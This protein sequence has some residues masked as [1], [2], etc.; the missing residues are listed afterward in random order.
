[1][2]S[3][4]FV[5]PVFFGT[6]GSMGGYLGLCTRTLGLEAA[7]SSSVDLQPNTVQAMG[8]AKLLWALALLSLAAPAI[9][10]PHYMVIVPAI[11]SHPTMENICVLLRFLPETVNL[12]VTLTIRTQNYTLVDKDVEKPGTFE[13]ISFRVPD[14]LSG[15]TSSDIED[16]VASVHVLI[17]KDGI[18]S[19][20]GRKKVLVRNA[21]IRHIIEPDKPFYKPGETVSF[22]IVRLDEE[23]KAINRTIP[24]IQLEDP[25]GNRIGQ[26]V[27]VEPRH[28]IVDLSFPLA[29]E[30]ALGTYVI[31]V[32]NANPE[33]GKRRFTVQEYELHK[34][35]VWFEP[36]PLIRTSDE[37]FE[38]TVCGKYTYGKTVRGII[39]LSLERRISFFFASDTEETLFHIRKEYT[40]QTDKTGCATFTING[41]DVNLSQKGYDRSIQASAEME[42]EGTGVKSTGEDT[43]IISAKEVELHFVLLN[44]FYKQGF[45]Y[46]GLMYVSVE[47]SPI[48]NRTVYLT[49]DVD[50]VQTHTTYVTNEN[51]VVNFSLDTTTWNNTMVSLRGRYSMENATQSETSHMSIFEA[52]TWLKPFYSESSS[53][54]EIQQ[55]E[56]EVP[57]GKDQEVRVEYILDRKELGPDADHVDFYYLVLSKG[58]IVYSGQKQVTVGHEET[59]KGSFSLILST[60]SDVAPIARILVYAVF[61][62]GEVAAD[63]DVFL[64]E[65]CFKQKVSL[66]FS[67]EEQLPGSEV[68][69]QIEAAPGALCSLHAVDKSV[70]LKENATLTP[71]KV[72]AAPM[73]YGSDTITG[74]GFPYRLEDFEPY[75]CLRPLGPSQRQKRSL[76]VAPW[77]QSEADVYSLLKQ[78]RLKIFTNL[79]VKKPVSCELPHPERIAFRRNEIGLPGVSGPAGSAKDTEVPL[80]LNAIEN[81]MD[82][83]AKPRTYFPETWIWDLTPVD[84]EGKA[85]HSVTVPDTITDWN[86]NAFCVADIG[87]GLSQPATL[88]VFKPF[89]VELVLPYSVVR[90]E[91]LQLK[92]TV[93][94]YLKDCIQVRVHLLESQDVEVKPCPECHFTTCLC[95]DE[96]KTFSWNVTATQLGQV[97]LS[98]TTEAEE[99][100]E[101]CGNQISV[102]P[103]R[104]RSDTV[105]KALLVKPEGVLEEE[106]HNV[107]LCSSG[108]PVLDEVSLELPGDVVSGS[109]RATVSTIGDI[110]GAALQNVDQLLQM[111][112][113]CGEQNMAKF[114]PNIFILQYL[115][116]TNQVTAENKEKG[117]EYMKSGYQRQLL[118]KRDDGSYSAFGKRDSEGNTW[119]TAFVAKAF[120]QAKPYVYIDEKHVQDALQ[121]LSQHQRPSGCFESVG[122]LFNN[123]L[124]GGVEDD[125][126]LTAYVTASLLE[127]HVEKNHSMVQD[128]LL[129]LKKNL[130]SV[131]DAYP[132][133]ILAYVFTLAGETEARQQLLK[134]LDELAIKTEGAITFSETETSAYVLLAYLSTSEVSADDITYASQIVRALTRAQNSYGGFSSTQ[135]TVVS[136]QALAKY[137]GLTYR[138][139]DDLKVLVK[140]SGGFQH[141]FHV[142]KKNRLLLQQASLPEVPGQYKVE[143]L[144]SGCVYVQTNLQYN[145]V[146]PKPE[147][148]LLHVETSPK[149]CNQTTKKHFDV[150]LQV[151]YAG[152]RET[153]NMVLLEVNMLSGYIPVKKSVKKLLINP[154]IK[155]VEPEHDKISIYLDQLDH[156]V[157]NYGFSV[158]QETEVMDLKAATVNIY[159]YY[160][161]EDKAVAEYNA[162][163][164]AE[165]MKEDQ[166]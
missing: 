121:W 58:K 73:F 30:A 27:D 6:E 68:N 98:V 43:I 26:W 10:D 151:S 40:G 94:N 32:G 149:E 108:D 162:P 106:T 78:L 140:S 64:I 138:E 57:C 9:S 132:K 128:A 93:F 116:K 34:I 123:A 101:L 54:L 8:A 158:K 161:P 66:S 124:K 31:T 142:G 82:E 80:V 44:S 105:V 46:T 117:T 95:A 19:F 65:K 24:L 41:T 85:T 75:P 50:D 20:E 35:E 163:C 12:Q 118:Y 59:L 79:E 33:L 37:E 111:P 92:A 131:S 114:V 134:D 63:V 148:F 156:S 91:T 61:D 130:T 36:T 42:E 136:L 7:E 1:M 159:D 96:A 97:N 56:E 104:G 102:A 127:A 2:R 125:L 137:A 115:E 45:P 5:V 126:S 141:E 25:N 67:E 38:V 155:K 4:H 145:K 51:G 135:D 86:A 139:I 14:F 74:R 77:Y 70:V 112:F 152:Q 48:Q 15:A 52:F 110:M 47:G 103:A 72:Y 60:S 143:L 147:G 84:E 89:F 120:G 129:C 29:S 18:V 160:H 122:R 87:F 154:L 133:A 113:G 107:F 99:T 100:Q 69:L 150:N 119:L 13:C 55:L 3:V 62:D 81:K 49:V 16:T 53:F 28:G 71:E 23:F 83:K 144:G 165:S 90:G 17:R 76:K 39:Y 166:H 22:R 21:F 153:S 109:G 157:Q 164:S 146:P 11:I 88:R